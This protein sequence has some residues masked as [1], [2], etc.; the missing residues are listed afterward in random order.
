MAAAKPTVILDEAGARRVDGVT[1]DP[2]IALVIATSGTSGHPHLA[3]LPAQA[4]ESAVLASASASTLA[5]RTDGSPACRWHT[6][7]GC[8]CSSAT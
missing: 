2:A 1:I 7:A 8:S 3:E 4:V 5:R 6:S